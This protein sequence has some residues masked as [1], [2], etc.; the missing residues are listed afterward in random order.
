VA[1]SF[2]LKLHR[3]EGPFFGFLK[4]LILASMRSSFTPPR[5]IKPLF[6]F[7]YHAHYAV[8]FGFRQFLNIIYRGP[9]FKA[10]CETVGRNLSIWSMPAIVGPVRIFIG[11]DVEIFGHLGVTS[12]RIFD[13]PRL[14]I[15]DRVDIGHN[16]Q[17]TVNRE[18]VIEEEVNIAS[19]VR[20]LDTDA[21]PR[22]TDARA[23][24]LPPPEAEIKAVRIGRRA[25]LGQSCFIMKGV[26]V[27]EGAVIGANSV[28][29][30]DIPPYAV[31]IGN[32]ARVVV[33]DVRQAA[34]PGKS[35]EPAPPRA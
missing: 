4:R 8:S 21:H 25:W 11:D 33:K 26:T 28:V 32:P 23:K 16:I 10:R 3:G 13:E 22:D 2:L 7:F 6:C 30:T 9:L 17:I 20:I 35:A 29:V 15:G 12:G 34:A 19:G 14:V 18:V 24:G 31:A 1:R 5:A 27:G